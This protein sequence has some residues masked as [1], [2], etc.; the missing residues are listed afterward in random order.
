MS[1]AQILMQVQ[2]MSATPEPE[3]YRGAL[4][5]LR[6]I[7]QREGWIVRAPPV[8]PA[9]LTAPSASQCSR[10]DSHPDAA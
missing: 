4:D 6:R 10:R 1:P 3:R 2:A 5:A 9:L 7:P 8:Q